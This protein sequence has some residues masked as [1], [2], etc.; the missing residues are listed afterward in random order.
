MIMKKAKELL[1]QNCHYGWPHA[2]FIQTARNKPKKDKWNWFHELPEVVQELS[3]VQIH[4]GIK[5]WTL[6]QSNIKIDIQE[7]IKYRRCLSIIL[8]LLMFIKA[9]NIVVISNHYVPQNGYWLLGLN[10]NKLLLKWI[11]CDLACYWDKHKQQ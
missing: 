9:I 11:P 1:K 3:I 4:V 8:C 10:I 5:I 2:D 6:F 7:L